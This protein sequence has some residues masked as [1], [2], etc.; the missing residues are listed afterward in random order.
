M[1]DRDR[2]TRPNL[3]EISRVHFRV[4]VVRSALAEVRNEMIPG[5]FFSTVLLPQIEGR[6]AA[7]DPGEV[8]QRGAT[9]G[10]LLNALIVVALDHRSFVSPV[11]LA[12]AEVHSHRRGSY[13]LDLVGI[14]TP[15]SITRTVT[16]GF[17]ARRPATVFPAVPPPTIIKSK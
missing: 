10:G 6:L 11:V 15:A 8:I 4:I 17:S 14:A 9:T 12:A 3:F 1:R 13:L 2:A 16:S 7:G 5:P